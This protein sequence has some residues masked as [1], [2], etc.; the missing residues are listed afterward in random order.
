MSS[1]P[2]FAA[3][4]LELLHPLG[5]ARSRRMFGGHG[6]YVDDVFIAIASGDRLY[7][8]ADDLT[9]PRFE[10]AGCEPFSYAGADDHVTVLSYWTAPDDAM[11]SPMLMQPWAR[12]AME[13][14][15]RARNAR[16]APRKKTPGRVSPARAA[17]KKP[18]GPRAKR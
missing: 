17:A 15:L 3:H 4:C 13:A 14:A 9:R 6:F 12:L 5:P 1:S 8:K 16:P 7:L 11:E 2:E 10:A 18:A